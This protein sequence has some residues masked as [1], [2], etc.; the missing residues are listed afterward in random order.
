MQ[1][2]YD[3]QKM[4]KSTGLKPT[5]NRLSILEILGEN[6]VPLTVGDIHSLL[7][8]RCRINQVTVYR[9]LDLLDK[10][11]LVERLSTSSKAAH[12]AL[13]HPNKH[14]AHPHFYCKSCG[15]LDCLS[16]ESIELDAMNLERNFPG[17]VERIEVRVDGIC[18]KCL[19]DQGAAL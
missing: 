10:Y 7:A 19:K 18:K 13:T 3:Y 2:K 14:A 4:L 9:V 17:K 15:Q 6:Q 12:Y 16:P 5:K 1:T 8:R 11:G